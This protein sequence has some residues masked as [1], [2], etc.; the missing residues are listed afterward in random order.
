MG[1][2]TQCDPCTLMQH[3]PSSLARTV[4][5]M[6]Q[7]VALGSL[8]FF[9][10]ESHHGSFM[11]VAQSTAVSFPTLV[12]DCGCGWLS[13]PSAIVE[14]PASG[15]GGVVDSNSDGS[16]TLDKASRCSDNN[17]PLESFLLFSLESDEQDSNA[18]TCGVYERVT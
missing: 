10:G 16:P 5:H 11:T 14:S 17:K 9:T 3:L 1:D 8:D 15:I 6:V 4:S 18:G 12:T 13:G 7:I 2:I